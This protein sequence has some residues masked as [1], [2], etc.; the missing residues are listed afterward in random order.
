MLFMMMMI[1]GQQYRIAEVIKGCV[2]LVVLK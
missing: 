1:E 2:L